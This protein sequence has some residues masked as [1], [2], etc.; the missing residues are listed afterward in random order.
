MTA[1]ALIAFGGLLGSSH[2]VGMCGGFALTVGMGTRG[3]VRNL[4]RQLVYSAGRIFTYAF[5]GAAA[6]FAGFWF[7]RRTTQLIHAQALLSFLAGVLLIAQGCLALGFVPARV[8]R[9][10]QAG[11][12]ASC[13]AGSFVRPFLASPRW[14]H[15]FV[16]GMLNGLLPCGLVYG[17]L[18]L[19]S[20][21]ASLPHGL[22][23][24]A[25]F[26]AGTVPAMA[27][28]GLGA[29]TFSLAA[30][31]G[32]FRVAGVCVL[33][34]GLAAVAR[35]V[36]FYRSAL[37][38]HCPGCRPAATHS[39]GAPWGARSIGPE[40]NHRPS[41]L[42]DSRRIMRS[43]L[44]D[45]PVSEPAFRTSLARF[46]GVAG[47]WNAWSAESRSLRACGPRP[48]PIPRRNSSRS[49]APAC[50][51][52]WLASSPTWTDWPASRRSLRR[53]PG[54]KAPRPG[55]SATGDDWRSPTRRRNG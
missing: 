19:A 15:V 13:L 24:M 29:S 26:G 52:C 39:V 34:T 51:E 53:G 12:G 32:L 38:P 6:G 30:R 45:G 1:L 23:V 20:S 16:A 14:Y 25:A 5:L 35:G 42:L 43:P 7:A 10:G 8:R 44:G 27:L 4:A 33:L 50:S 17:Y 3:P 48:R 40:T 41:S 37:V 21:S 36:E 11:A 18:A 22:C 9:V 47:G 28:V 54:E 49:T 46:A 2:C 55:A 31:R